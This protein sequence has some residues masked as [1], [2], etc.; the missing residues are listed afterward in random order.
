[1]K[2]S[3]SA[4]CA[5]L[6]ALLAAW[7]VAPATSATAEDAATP[8]TIYWAV[9]GDLG[10]RVAGQ[11]SD[12]TAVLGAGEDPVAGQPLTLSAYV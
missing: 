6:A 1:M 3:W 11:P 10:S 5:L 12:L 4:V 8:T 2:R 9:V 7:L